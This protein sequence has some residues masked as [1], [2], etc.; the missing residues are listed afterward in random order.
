MKNV[1]LGIFGIFCVIYTT[2][3]SLT[4]YAIQSR[5]N[6]LENC[7]SQVI[8]AVLKEHYSPIEL[9]EE[10]HI[11]KSE[12]EIRTQIEQEIRLRIHSET[13]VDVQ[14]LVCNMEK[15]ILSVL[16]KE[17]FKLPNGHVKTA[18]YSKTAIMEREMQDKNEGEISF[19]VNGEIYKTYKKQIGESYPIPK[20][21][22]GEFL[23]WRAEKENAISNW[24]NALQVEGN[25]IWIAVF[26]DNG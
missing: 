4:I 20:V 3:I 23:Y 21:P 19:Y 11:A 8:E 6:E 7:L 24:N 5:K 9:R 18:S 17:Q 2:I 1:I 22:Q 16:V 26:G 13:L 25:D 12:E 10:S 15:G 14:I